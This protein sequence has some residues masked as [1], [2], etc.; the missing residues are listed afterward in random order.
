MEVYVLINR[1]KGIGIFIL[2]SILMTLT[3]GTLLIAFLSPLFFILTVV[4]GLGFYGTHFLTNIEYEYSYFGGEIKFCKI[5]NKSKRKALLRFPMDEVLKI[6]PA[7]DESVVY[8]EKDKNYVVTD[9]T[10]R[11]RDVSYYELFVNHGEKRQCIK[12]E[13][14]DAFLKEIRI[15]YPSKVVTGRS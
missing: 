12:F 5:I 1:K 14:D 6:A 4:F 10:S 2:D 9:L 7:G 15:K 8:F 3:I 13:P 11:N